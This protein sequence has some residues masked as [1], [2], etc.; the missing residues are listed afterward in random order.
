MVYCTTLC[1]YNKNFDNRIVYIIVYMKIM[2]KHYDNKPKVYIAVN[3]HSLLYIRITWETQCSGP[4]LGARNP[5][6]PIIYD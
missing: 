2:G 1:S 4:V 3:Y 5:G 6:Q